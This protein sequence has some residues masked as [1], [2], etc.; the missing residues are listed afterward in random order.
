V[1]AQDRGWGQ[2]WPNCQAAS[3]IRVVCGGLGLRLPVRTEIATLIPPLVHDLEAARGQPFRPDWSWGYAC[4][5]IRQ[6]TKPSNHSWGLAIDLDAPENPQMS[7]TKHGEAHP[8]RKTFPGGLVM[9][10][11][12]PDDVQAIAAKHGFNWG[13]LFAKPDPMHF[14]F[15]GTPADALRR[16]SGLAPGVEEHRDEPTPAAGLTRTYTVKAGDTLSQIG[17]RLGVKWRKLAEDN[18]IAS[19]DFIIRPGQVLWF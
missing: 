12:M 11:T 3:I 17:Q 13:G 15:L 4:R 18:N 2:G 5:A 9:R 8:L 6:S 16:A 1:S 14:E 10:S 19:P 7:K